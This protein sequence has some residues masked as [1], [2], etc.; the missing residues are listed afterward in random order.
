LLIRIAAEAS[1]GQK[2]LL[3]MCF[4]QV[5]IQNRLGFALLA[6]LE[7]ILMSLPYQF[8]HPNFDFPSLKD[9]FIHHLVLIAVHDR[10]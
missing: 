2:M 10:L 7:K 9:K 1:T 6:L 4:F 5:Q 8:L 3:L